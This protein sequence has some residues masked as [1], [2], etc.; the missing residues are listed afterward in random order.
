MPRRLRAGFH[1]WTLRERLAWF[2]VRDGEASPAAELQPTL[3]DRVRD[4]S[5]VDIPLPVNSKRPIAP[6]FARRSM[7]AVAHGT[8]LY[9][10]GGVGAAGTESILDVTDDLWRFDT[11]HHTWEAIPRSTPWPSARRCLGWTASADLIHLWGGSGIAIDTTQRTRHT[12]LNDHWAFDPRSARWTLLAESDDHRLAPIASPSEP[13]PAPRY[14]P[15]YHAVGN[16]RFLFGGYTE[17]RLGKRKLNDAWIERDLTWREV[18]ATTPQGYDVRSRWPGLRYGSISATDGAHVFVCG[19]FSDDG[20][21]NDVWAFDV[22]DERWHLL[23]PDTSDSDAPAPRYCAAFAWHDGRLILFGGRSRGNPKLNFNDLWTFTLATGRWENIEP[24]RTP[25]RYDGSTPYPGYHAKSSTAVV[26][27]SLY[28]W[29]GEGLH[30]HV[31][32]L[33]TLDMHSMEW[34]M[35]LPARGDAQCSG[36]APGRTPMR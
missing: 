23:S 26:E 31:S 4:C 11:L 8:D 5:A 28:L 15:L 17:D 1:A 20:D 10:I 30:G 19:G 25:H 29:G 24:V 9:L 18:P 2:A 35:L 22:S 13:R 3:T 33:W 12:F 7:A 34:V 14:T 32:D 6:L 21:H 16:T 36:N 27:H